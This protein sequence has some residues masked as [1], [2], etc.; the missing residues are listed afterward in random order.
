MWRPISF[1]LAVGD[2]GISYVGPEHAD[3]LMSALEMYYKKITTYLE[4]KLYCGIT[5]KWDYTKLYV[6]ISMPRYVK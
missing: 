3:H 2:F 5:M 6:D 1:K 4:G